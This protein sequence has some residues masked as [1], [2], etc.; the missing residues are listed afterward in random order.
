[1]STT[2]GKKRLNFGWIGLGF[3]LIG[4]LTVGIVF[5][6]QRYRERKEQTNPNPNPKV[7]VKERSQD[8]NRAEQ[9]ETFQQIK[10]YFLERGFNETFA[11]TL[12]AVSCHETGRWSSNLAN[13]YNNIFGMKANGA[14]T[15]ISKESNSGF[16]VYESYED[17]I[18]DAA[19][20]FLAKGYPIDEDMQP[21]NILQ[22]M[23]SKKYMEAPLA[24]Y[25]KSVLSL[26]NELNK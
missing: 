12:A 9:F 19:T 23:K 25:K 10:D 26:L 4:L 13:N 18:E 21:E 16:A 14:G 11:S 8:A 6:I 24:D 22:W 20:W 1:M 15:G 2:I 5:L 7:N 3:I 17:S